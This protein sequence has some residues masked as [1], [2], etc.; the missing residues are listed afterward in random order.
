M[1][2]SIAVLIVLGLALVPL[3]ANATLGPRPTT[4]QIKVFICNENALDCDRELEG[5]ANKWLRNEGTK[6]VISDRKLVM[7]DGRIVLVIFYHVREVA[8][9]VRPPAE[10]P[11]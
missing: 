7:S 3:T 5:D 1:R 4:E 6:I 2:R 10:K 9:A 11:E 8:P